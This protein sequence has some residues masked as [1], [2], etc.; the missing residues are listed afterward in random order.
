MEVLSNRVGVSERYLYRIEN[1]GQ[2]PSFDVLNKLVHE[3]AISPER[4]F[5]PEKPSKESEVENL[6]RM[7]YSCDDQALKV[8]RATIKAL[9]EME[10]D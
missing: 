4:I 1:E 7:L 9:I 8:V 5:Y 3:L 6:T 10:A 2:K